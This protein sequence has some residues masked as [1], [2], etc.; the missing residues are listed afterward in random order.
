MKVCPLSKE[1]TS[2]FLSSSPNTNKAP[3]MKQLFLVKP[4]RGASKSKA[5]QTLTQAPF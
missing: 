2:S 3:I 4:E 5:H 1:Y